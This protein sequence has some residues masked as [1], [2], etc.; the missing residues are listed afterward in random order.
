MLEIAI[1]KYARKGRFLSGDR[2]PKERTSAA[3]NK[4][5]NTQRFIIQLIPF[6]ILALAVA[7]L[8][9][10]TFAQ[11]GSASDASSLPKA[12]QV[13]PS[14]RATSGGGGVQAQQSSNGNGGTSSVNTVNS[15]IQVSGAYLGS[16]PDPNAPH[17]PLTLNI[18]EAIGRRRDSPPWEPPHFQL[19]LVPSTITVRLRTSPKT[20][21]SLR[22]TTFGKR[23]PQRMRRR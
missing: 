15:T 6:G 23:K 9:G 20:S 18:A 16:I 21:A 13:T 11:Q 8:S 10:T 4:G 12:Q 17:G 19:L 14:G 22:C 1:I 3:R 5:M 7:M 2:I